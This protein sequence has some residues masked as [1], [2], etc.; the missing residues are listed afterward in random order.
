[1]F[2]INLFKT[3]PV[4][5]VTLNSKRE[6]ENGWPSF[7]QCNF[8]EAGICDY[9]DRDQGIALLKKETMD[10]WIQTFKGKPVVIDHQDVSPENFNK[11]K[12]K[13]G[14]ITNVWFN[15]A[16]GWYWAEFIV[17]KDEGHKIIQDGWSVSCSFDVVATAGGG[18]WHASK[19]TEEITEGAG[20]HL[21]LVEHPRYEDCRISRVNNSAR[22]NS[23]D[24]KVNA[25]KLEVV[26]KKDNVGPDLDIMSPLQLDKYMG[27]LS[28]VGIQSIID[29]DYSEEIKTI[30]QDHQG[31]RSKKKEEEL[32]Q[33]QP[34]KEASK[35]LFKLFGKKSTVKDNKIDADKVF[36]DVDGKKVPLATLMNSYEDMEV[37]QET[38]S[39][40]INGKDVSIKD[41]V[42]SYKSKSNDDDKKKDDDRK[43]D[44]EDEEKKDD[45]KKSKNDDDK[46]GCDKKNDD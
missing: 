44:D 35:M 24:C 6:N 2:T 3:K 5:Q 22:W 41:L 30:A 18:E 45:D 16:D 1:M 37:L 19:Y 34:K 4:P 14:Y 13:V 38:D 9:T 10:S 46:K 25:G 32:M 33:Q 7:Y 11:L 40:K 29:G 43:D 31:D 36:V 21:A 42:N 20:L 12:D 15:P 23:K 8:L 39:V 28:D 17:D 27:S 26:M